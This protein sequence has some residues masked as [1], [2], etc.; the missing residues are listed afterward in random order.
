LRLLLVILAGLCWMI[1]L[2][3][4]AAAHEVNPAFLELTETEFGQFDVVWKQP[5]KDGRRLKLDPVF[6]EDCEASPIALEGAVGAVVSRWTLSCALNEGEIRVDGL[7]RTLTDVFVQIHRIDGSVASVVLKPAAAAFELG[8]ETS[9]APLLAYFRI[10]VD[11]IIFGYDHLLFVLG[12]CLLVRPSQLLLTVTAFT[13]AHSITLGLSTLAG[14]TLPGPPVESVIA[15]SLILL[16]REAI[17]L[18][19]GGRS[20]TSQYPW[21]IAFGFGLIHGFGFAGALADIGLPK[22][23]EIWA[24]LL[25][26]LGVEAGQVA[27]VIALAVLAAGLTYVARNW[28]SRGKIAAAYL[29]G[30]SGTIW[31]VERVVAF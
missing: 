15:L 6:P 11:H 8:E 13:V 7:D 5:I 3:P 19:R 17:T 18:Q 12:L 16:A 10:G 1:G 25:F 9:S 22:D 23:Q 26:N 27:F 4:I 14:I 29:V 30:V 2:S 20:L 31:L 28:L 21:A 24:L